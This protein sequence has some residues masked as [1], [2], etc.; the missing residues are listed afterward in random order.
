[1]TIKA[2]KPQLIAALQEFVNQRPGFDPRNYGSWSSYQADYRPVMKDKESFREL[3]RFA[4]LF[5]IDLVGYAEREK[6]GR[7][8]WNDDVGRFDYCTGQY[9]PTEFRAAA[10]RWVAGAIWEYFRANGSSPSK[11]AKREF[12]R[13]TANRFFV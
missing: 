3:I 6:S 12:S 13:R 4:E 2:T 5:S 10:C 7:L 8:T 11:A 9:F 1:M